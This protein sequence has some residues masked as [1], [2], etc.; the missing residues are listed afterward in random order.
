LAGDSKALDQ[1]NRKRIIPLARHTR[2]RL[3]MLEQAPA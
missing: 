3:A 1:Y 2:E